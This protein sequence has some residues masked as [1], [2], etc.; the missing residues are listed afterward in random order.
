MIKSLRRPIEYPSCIRHALF[1][2]GRD[3]FYRRPRRARATKKF[4]GFIFARP[5]END[6]ICERGIPFLP[7]ML[8]CAPHAWHRQPP[9]PISCRGDELPHDGHVA[10]AAG[11]AFTI[12]GGRVGRFA[13]VL[14]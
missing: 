14:V 9:P 7:S 10:G 3:S 5:P 2:A 6:S 13:G 8:V 4:G 11:R 1:P 12:V